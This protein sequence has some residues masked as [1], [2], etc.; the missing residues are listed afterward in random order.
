MTFFFVDALDECDEDQVRDLVDFFEKLT[1]RACDKG[2]PLRICF[3]SRHYPFISIDECSELFVEKHN[4][5]DIRLYVQDQAKYEKK[6]ASLAPTIISKASGVFLW[7]VLVI[8]RLRKSAAGKSLAALASELAAVPPKLEEL[9]DTLFSNN[10]EH[11]EK[12]QTG[13][14]IQL[15]LFGDQSF[16]AKDL[17]FALALESKE[18]PESVKSWKESYRIT[19]IDNA[20]ETISDEEEL[21]DHERMIIELSRGLLEFHDG[22]AE[23]IHESVRDFFLKGSGSSFLCNSPARECLSSLGHSAIASAC[24]KCLQI[25][26]IRRLQ[27]SQG[28]FSSQPGDPPFLGYAANEFLRHAEIAESEGISQEQSLSMVL[29]GQCRPKKLSFLLAAYSTSRFNLPQTMQI[30]YEFTD[31]SLLCSCIIHN[32]IACVKRLIEM[33]EVNLEEEVRMYMDFEYVEPGRRFD[34]GNLSQRLYA[35]KR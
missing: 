19:N 29:H 1:D 8:S 27:V 21:L 9:F 6:F 28:R 13:L 25:P 24:A 12:A 10:M 17:L 3:S 26:D 22:K 33:N 35:C 15:V 31:P 23:F 2:P 34:Y 7:V 30:W 18:P 14:L 5:K 16:L 11:D 4:Y 20:N 32:S